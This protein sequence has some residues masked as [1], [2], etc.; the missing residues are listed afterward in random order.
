MIFEI[1]KKVDTPQKLQRVAG[2]PTNLN[3][4]AD[5][6]NKVAGSYFGVFT[7]EL[8]ILRF[9]SQ[10]G[11]V[12]YKSLFDDRILESRINLRYD[13][14]HFILSKILDKPAKIFNEPIGGIF[15]S[16]EN[17]ISNNLNYAY[18]Y[19]G[20]CSDVVKGYL[21]STALHCF[22]TLDGNVPFSY[23]W[24]GSY[25]QMLFSSDLDNRQTYFGMFMYLLYS[26]YCYKTL[27]ADFN[28]L[29][30]DG[31]YGH[32]ENAIEFITAEINEIK[33]YFN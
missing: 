15:G 28:D 29:A 1:E 4:F 11:T 30:L 16:I 13:I 32:R 19:A 7:D 9:V 20:N 12:L 8:G 2:Q 24:N 26:A 31:D 25:E 22:P 18:P 23:E 10:T 33:A 17:A 3:I 5:E 27:G 6:F 14:Y 21:L